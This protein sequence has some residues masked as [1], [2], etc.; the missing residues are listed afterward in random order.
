MLGGAISI[1]TILAYTAM[2]GSVGGGG[3][4]FRPVGRWLDDNGLRPAC[5]LWFTDLECS[6]FPDE[7]ACPLLWAVWGQGGEQPPFGEL[8]RLP[9]GA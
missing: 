1:V 4:D 2:A 6:S 9:A 3:S 5:L 7:P 8:L